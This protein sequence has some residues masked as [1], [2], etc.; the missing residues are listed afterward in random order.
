MILVGSRALAL[1]TR[2]NRKPVD[3]DF[4]EDEQRFS[5]WYADATQKGRISVSSQEKLPNKFVS[6]GAPNIECEFIVPG[7]SA[8]MLAQLVEKDRTRSLRRWD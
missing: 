3:F 7:N 5:A 1:R 6:R 2:L 4:I 8:S